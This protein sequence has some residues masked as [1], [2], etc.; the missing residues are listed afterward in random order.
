[1]AQDG[2]Y[3]ALARL[4]AAFLAEAMRRWDVAPPA[5]ALTPIAPQSDDAA[6][7]RCTL[8]AFNPALGDQ[9]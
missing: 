6:C 5:A 2:P 3:A 7:D 1:V 8:A 9:S 4:L